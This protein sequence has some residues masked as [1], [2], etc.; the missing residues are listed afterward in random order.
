[1]SNSS[2]QEVRDRI[3]QLA[4][5]IEEFSKTNSPPATFFQEFL[6]RVVGA[7]GARGGAVWLR[8]GANRLELISEVGL[9][10]TG[11]NE[12]PNALA[13]NQKLLNEVLSNGQACTHHPSDTNFEL[14][15]EDMLVLAALQQN[16][17]VVGVVEVFQRNDTPAQARPGFLQFVEQMT[18]YACRYL[19]LQGHS[20]TETASTGTVGQ[21]AEEFEQ[22]VLQ[23]YKSLDPR[24]V[25]YTAAND[26]RLLI[27]C[28]RLSIVV[29]D[30]KKAVVRGVSGQEKV[31]QRAN[32][33]RR[34]TKLSQRV[35]R[36]KET[37]LYTGKVDHLAPKVE[38]AL[39]DFVQESGSRMVAVIPVYEPEPLVEKE[40]DRARPKEKVRKPVGGLIVE[41]VA[42]SQ[43]KTGTI[44]KAELIA[45]HVGSAISNAKRYNRIFLMPVWRGL[46][47]VYS[48]LEGKNRLKAA[49][50]LVLIAAVI[51]A[52]VYIPWEYRV[53]G[54][55]RLVPVTQADVFAP[56]DGEV[57]AILVESGD[58]VEEGD[59]LLIIE[60]KD[61][62][63][64]WQAAIGE[65]DTKEQLRDNLAIMH[66]RLTGPEDKK[67]RLEIQGQWMETGKQLEHLEKQIA[68]LKERREKLVVKAPISGVVATFQLDQLLKNRPVRRGELLVEIKDDTGDWQ[69]ELEVE[70]HRIGH[71]LDAQRELKRKKLDV[72]FVLATDSES[73]VKGKLAKI[74]TRTNSSSEL[75]GIIIATATIE[76]ELPRTPRIG[77]EVRA[78]ISCGE[79][80]LGYVLF[81]DVVEF[82]QKYFWL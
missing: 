79:K 50:C 51:T 38:K 82:V 57:A 25:A 78:K 5:E 23:L 61:L 63:Q 81:G 27:G 64:Q 34:M 9:A 26:G 47:K 11:F 60:N 20:E 76:E 45:D 41:Q 19:D 31:N 65:F 28:D 74:D 10:A 13:V 4:R 66:G 32:L 33:I 68:I 44:E 62:D 18:G 21:V 12:N 6:K 52:M 3:I 49:L 67:Q 58:P 16:K 14:P 54:Q 17:E 40:D 46:G 7:V 56:W 39:A 73:P 42:E 77:A 2:V 29:L 35:I 43:P 70:E 22:F 15:T 48:F 72:E 80:S 55:G 8:N 71:I 36:S 37:L 75:G 69:L 1:M 59:E 30:G 24:D 53:E